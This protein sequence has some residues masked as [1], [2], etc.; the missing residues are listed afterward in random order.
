TRENPVAVAREQNDRYVRPFRLDLEKPGQLFESLW[1]ERF[2]CQD[3]RADTFAGPCAGVGNGRAGFAHNV[4]PAQDI[5]QQRGVAARRSDNQDPR[6]FLPHS[7]LLSSVFS[8]P[9]KTGVPV[10][11]PWN[12][13]RASPTRRPLSP[14]LNS[15]IVSSCFALRFFT[16]EMAFFTAPL[17]SK[18]RVRMTVSAR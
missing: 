10:R 17:T 9:V 6:V 16:T 18:N 12:S 13:V 7:A 15:R 1:I 2:L 14:M 3:Q 8:L 4:K 11:T 5:A